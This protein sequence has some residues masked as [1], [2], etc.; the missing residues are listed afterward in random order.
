MNISS[1]HRKMGRSAQ[2]TVA[3]WLQTVKVFTARG[4]T[5]IS[6]EARY[7]NSKTVLTYRCVCGREAKLSRD[8]AREK[9]DGCGDCIR[10][11]R[12]AT[13]RERY[14]AECSLQNAEVQEKIRA[15]LREKYGVEHPTQ[16]AEVREKI[17]ETT[18]KRYGVDCSLQSADVKE[19]IRATVFEKYGVKNPAQAAVVK[20]KIRMT[21]LKKYGVENPMQNA[22][23]REKLRIS[24]REKYGV[25]NSQQDRKI[26]EKTMKTSFRVKQFAFPSGLIIGC[27][28]Y[29]SFA[30]TELMEEGISEEEIVDGFAHIPTVQYCLA[31]KSHMYHPDIYIPAAN[32]II[33]VKSEYTVKTNTPMLSAKLHSCVAA[34]Y[35]VELRVYD[36]KGRR[37]KAVEADARSVCDR[38]QDEIEMSLFLDQCWEEMRGDESRD[39]ASP[40][41]GEDSGETS[42]SDSD[43]LWDELGL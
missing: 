22:Q 27:Q 26:H 28:G 18:R 30:I 14:G 41:A 36:R 20:E 7:V 40:V 17:R 19:K 29:E 32:R 39:S 2:R 24:I 13:N 11:K 12:R 42:I 4:F 10:E 8:R 43:P 5:L 34:G 16:S 33:E 15:S 23:I 9:R 35:R 25:D 3:E 31:G 1:Q 38:V 21:V 6:T 37:L